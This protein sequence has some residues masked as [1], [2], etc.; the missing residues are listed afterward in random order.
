MKIDESYIG[1]HRLVFL[2]I[3]RLEV[4]IDNE[5]NV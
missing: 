4:I 5:N 3:L 2:V 1:N